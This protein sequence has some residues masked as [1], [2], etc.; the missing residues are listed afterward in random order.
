MDDLCR[1]NIL[2]ALANHLW[3]YFKFPAGSIVLCRNGCDLDNL[4][5]SWSLFG[6]SDCQYIYFFVS[7]DSLVLFRIG[8]PV[9]LD[10]RE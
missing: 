3:A 7:I 8:Y 1:G 6:G 9:V 5:E 2:F 4:C 10:A